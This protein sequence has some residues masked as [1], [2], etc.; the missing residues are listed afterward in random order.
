[1]KF[2]NINLKYTGSSKK[3]ELISKAY[4][5]KGA[6]PI[7]LSYLLVFFWGIVN[8]IVY[9]VHVWDLT[10]LWERFVDA[11]ATVTPTILHN[12]SLE[13]TF[14]LKMFILKLIKVKLY[15]VLYITRIQ[16][17]PYVWFF[18]KYD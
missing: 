9:S 10:Y 5:R 2:L 14:H 13:L 18:I 3:F 4:K 8:N 17:F 7:K 12:T 1:M 6:S 16:L 15:Y 11:F